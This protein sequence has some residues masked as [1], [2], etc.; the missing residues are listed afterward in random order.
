MGF[1]LHVATLGPKCSG[2]V[3]PF[4]HGSGALDK[5]VLHTRGVRSFLSVPCSG[6]IVRASFLRC[7]GP[8]S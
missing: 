7:S 8:G 4:L 5:A 1:R 3:H 2:K 6:A